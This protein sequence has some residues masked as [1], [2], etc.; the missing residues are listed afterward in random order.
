MGHRLHA[1]NLLPRSAL[2]FVNMVDLG[3]DS[4]PP[5]LYSFWMWDSCRTGVVASPLAG[6][7]P[8]VTVTYAAYPEFVGIGKHLSSHF[9]ERGYRK[10]EA[11]PD[12]LCM[13]VSYWSY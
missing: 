13:L 12:Q 3:L 10:I 9:N 5:S 8:L 7:T 6:E 1:C 4:Q 11:R 2:Q